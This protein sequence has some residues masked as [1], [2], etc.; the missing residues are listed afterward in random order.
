M[1]K[2]IFVGEKFTTENTSINE[3]YS[4]STKNSFQNGELRK[5]VVEFLTPS[6]IVP[7]KISVEDETFKAM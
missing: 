3:L 2:I 4:I 7:L 5:N 1:L 6:R